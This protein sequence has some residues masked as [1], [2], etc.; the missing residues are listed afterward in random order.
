M[1]FHKGYLLMAKYIFITGGVVSS[2]GKGVAAATLGSLLQSRGYSVHSRKFDPYLNVDPGTMSP[3]QHGEVYV[4]DDGFETDLDLG[5]YE[6]FL[7]IKLSRDDSISGGRIYWD[8]LNAERR[9]DYLGGTVQMIPHVSNKIKEYIGRPVDADFV[10]CEIGG[11]VGDIEGKIFLESIR[12]FAND[13][14]RHNVM[15]VHLTFA[16]YLEKSGE[17]KTKPTQQS[18]RMLLENGIQADMLIV[19]TPRVLNEDERAKIGMFCN[20]SKQ[21]VISGIDADNIYKIPL[22]YDAQNVFDRLAEHFGLTVAA[23]DMSRFNRIESYLDGRLPKITIGIVGKYFNVPDAYKSLNEA[24]F[25]AGIQNNVHVG[26][27]KIDAETFQSADVADVDGILVPGG[28]GARGVDGKIAAAKYARE[29][30]VPYM[31]ICLGMQV[32]V[33]EFM[34]NVMGV[35]NANSTEF[36][37]D[38]APVIDIMPDHN[39]ADMGG[40]LR[41]GSYPCVIKPGSLAE[42]VYGGGTI[43]ERHRH[44]Y[45][46]DVRLEEQVA[47]HGMIISGKSPDGRLPEIIELADHPFFMAG[48]FHPD[49]QSG[50]YDG[51]PFFNAFIRACSARRQ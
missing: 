9:G 48:Q 22:D 31:G 50:P 42:K 25:H 35:A 19:R 20:L 40:T 2:L 10:I 7:G 1:K 32:A 6:R 16:P 12:Q 26:L 29:N 38:C 47:R 37:S 4:T 3:F 11:T 30:K 36:D 43:S 33:I 23:G 45:E 8:V 34:R 18:A 46:M 49:F 41:L 5:Y 27:K 17:L 24:L 51:H 28:F 39:A 14:G 44:R 21:N 15:F 13:F